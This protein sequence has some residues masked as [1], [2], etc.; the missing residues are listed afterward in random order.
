V[1]S[2]SKNF[3]KVKVTSE[4]GNDPLRRS[5]YVRAFEEGAADKAALSNDHHDHNFDRKSAWAMELPPPPKCAR[6]WG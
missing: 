2:H 3:Q 5:D 1:C 6:G 4:E